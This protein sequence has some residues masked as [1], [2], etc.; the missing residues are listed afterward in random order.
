MTSTLS[1]MNSMD[2]FVAYSITMLQSRSKL[3]SQRRICPWY[4]DD[5]QSAK[6]E[7]RRLE[8]RFI[9]TNTKEDLA[10][11]KTAKNRVNE[12]TDIAKKDYYQSKLDKTRA[13]SKDLFKTFNSLK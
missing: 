10:L 8:N 9:K 1:L 13:N 5:I 12:L 7:R 3:I 6:R 2:A 11:Y 4:N